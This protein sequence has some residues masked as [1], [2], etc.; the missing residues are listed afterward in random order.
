MKSTSRVRLGLLL[1][2]AAC[3]LPLMPLSCGDD[4]TAT[5]PE[6]AAGTDGTTTTTDSSKPDTSTKTDAPAD[7]QNDTTTEGGGEAAA[8]SAGGADADAGSMMDADATADVASN[9]DADA[10]AA[11]ADAGPCGM[12]TSPAVARACVVITGVD[13]VTAATQPDGA[14]DTDLDNMG[15]LLIYAFAVPDPADG[16]ADGGVASPIAQPIAYPPPDDAG[17]FTQEIPVSALTSLGPIP[18]DV[19]VTT[20]YILTY[21]IDNPAGFTALAQNSLTY[22]MYVG[23]LDLSQG[24]QPVPA[25]RAVTL[26][27]GQGT[28]VNQYLTVMRKFSTAVVRAPLPLPDGGEVLLPPAA[29]GDGTG[30][31]LIGAYRQA[32]VGTPQVYGGALVPCVDIIHQAPYPVSGF[33]YTPTPS[34]WTSDAGG[35]TWF[36]GELNDFGDQT[37]IPPA[38]SMVSVALDDAG[39]QVIPSTQ[40]LMVGATDYAVTIPFVAFTATTPPPSSGIDFLHCPYPPPDAGLDANS[41][42]PTDATGN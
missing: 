33:F 30:T 17:L 11:D 12:P 38:G 6:D 18:V 39:T 32:A 5:T 25:V 1:G 26:T 28:I 29:G 2:T 31:L 13:Q 42:A 37:T 19:P 23:G 22:G 16:G 34:T 14:A 36:S 9:A 21:F 40:M 3:T 20:A 10:S 7:T 35:D 8:D 41:D 15:T 24:I 4:T 27:A